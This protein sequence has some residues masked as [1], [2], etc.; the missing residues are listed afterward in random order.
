MHAPMYRQFQTTIWTSLRL[1]RDGKSTAVVDFVGKYREPVLSFIRRQGFSED[2][3]E[4]LCQEVFL[5]FMKD[6]LL[7]RADKVRG[8]FRGFLLGVTRNVIRN[9]HRIRAAAKRGGG[10]GAVSLDEPAG[11]GD[12]IGDLVEAGEPDETFD[13]DWIRHMIGLALDGLARRHPRRHQVLTMHLDERA[14]YADIARALDLDA[15]QVDNTLRQARATLGE[16][17]R[18]EV[19]AYCGS[20]EE[21]DDEIA[22]LKRFLVPSNS[23]MG[24]A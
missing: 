8:R 13:R 19:A 23:R 4:D 15:K 22:Y 11:E 9:A 18:A 20:R 2:D 3:A 1:A 16:L 17:L 21:Y 5:L 24:R 12:V 7:A 14:S 10:A 6:D